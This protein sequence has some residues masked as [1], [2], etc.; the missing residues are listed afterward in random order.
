M[1]NTLFF[2]QGGW[3]LFEIWVRYKQKTEEWLI[4]RRARET[5]PYVIQGSFKAGVVR[6]Y[7]CLLTTFLKIS[8]LEFSFFLHMAKNF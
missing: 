5:I 8:M 7:V 3:S 1:Y 6:S 2:L 4:K